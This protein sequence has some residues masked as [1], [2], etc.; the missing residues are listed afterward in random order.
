MRIFLTGISCVGK[1]TI[2]KILAERLRHPFFN[3]D[4][5]IELYFGESIERLRSRHMTGHSYSYKVGAV[6]LNDILFKRNSSNSVIALPPSGLMYAYL[7]IVKKI[8]GVVVAI[9]DRP[10]NILKRI[11]FYDI[12]SKP[13]EKELN[14][15][16]AA[17][18]LKEIKK[19]LTYFGKSYKR[20]HL[21]VDIAGL[22]VD[23]SVSRIHNAIQSYSSG[24]KAIVNELKPSNNK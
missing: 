4:T 18:Y 14:D 21:M 19:D 15:R 11:T 23:C 12:D 17:H 24:K 20:A 6:V 7:R 22:T 1:T 2:G 8:E 5:E 13:I 3:L 10:E 16:E 9:T